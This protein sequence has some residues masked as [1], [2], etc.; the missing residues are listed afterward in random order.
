MITICGRVQRRTSTIFDVSCQTYTK[1]MI[2]LVLSTVV[3]T[4]TDHFIRLTTKFD[5]K[6]PNILKNSLSINLA[7]S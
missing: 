4:V 6:K 1:Q 3:N 2:P 5:P 7:N